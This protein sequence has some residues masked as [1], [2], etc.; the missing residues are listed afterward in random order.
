MKE[1]KSSVLRAVLEEEL[2]RSV[3]ML[4]RY[5]EELEKLPRGTIV[6]RPINEQQY[7]YLSYRVEKKVVTKYIGNASDTDISELQQQ[8]ARRKHIKEIIKKL[9]QEQKEIESAI[10]KK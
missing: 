4:A 5:K 1:I 3:R 9:K 10:R 8:L 7:Y 2:D 6:K